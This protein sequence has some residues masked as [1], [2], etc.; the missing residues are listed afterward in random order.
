MHIIVALLGFLGF[1]AVWYWRLKM[2]RDVAR[3]GRK[4]AETVANLPRKMRFRH[5]S[6]KGGLSVVEDPREA[7]TILM[8]EI[9]QARGTLT[10]KQ[11]AVIR[12][13]IMHQ[14]EFAE[15]DANSLISQAGWLSR[16]AGASHVVMSKMTDFVR[17]SP[18]MTNKELV[19]LDG[20]L[21]AISEAEGDPT[22]SQLDLL[23]IYRDKTGLRV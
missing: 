11:E 21:V 14:F 6:G 8:L 19:D 18:G 10:E 2:L 23:M 4:V 7:A 20:M 15:G 1:I 17:K 13:E 3:D 12:G 22:A 9:A 16:S 5:Q